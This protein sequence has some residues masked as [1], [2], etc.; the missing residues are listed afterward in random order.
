MPVEAGE[1]RL[2]SC[3]ASVGSRAVV[4]IHPPSGKRVIKLVSSVVSV[5]EAASVRREDKGPD[6][7]VREGVTMPN[8]DFKH[9]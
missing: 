3:Q 5:A 2:R 8:V 7:Q 4:S 9:A 1:A 6:P